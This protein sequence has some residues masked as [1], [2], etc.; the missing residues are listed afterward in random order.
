MLVSR[1]LHYTIVW[2]GKVLVSILLELVLVH[3]FVFAF[4]FV[5]INLV[6]GIR[7]CF[8]LFSHTM[9]LFHGFT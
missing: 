6:L 8:I 1:D 5:L 3:V 4:A 9:L 2:D 7:L